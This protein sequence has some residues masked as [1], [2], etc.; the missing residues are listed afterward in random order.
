MG[1]EVYNEWLEGIRSR[2]LSRYWIENVHA[3]LILVLVLTVDQVTLAETSPFGSLMALD[4]DWRRIMLH[5]FI[6]CTGA[7]NLTVF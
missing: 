6:S 5:A 3:Y 2:H 1:Y 7:W 4:V